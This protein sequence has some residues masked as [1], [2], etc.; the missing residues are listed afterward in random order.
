MPLGLIA[1]VLRYLFLVALLWYVVWVLRAMMQSMPAPV[2]EE[3]RARAPRHS[4]PRRP[5]GPVAADA[6]PAA[7]EP[8]SPP[9]AESGPEPTPEEAPERVQEE[10]VGPVVVQA[11]GEA[12]EGP[13]PPEAQPQQSV[14]GD[15][16]PRL[17]LEVVPVP[18]ISARRPA[19][20]PSPPAPRRLAGFELAVEEPGRSSLPRGMA[21][22]LRVGLHI[23]RAADNGLVID[24]PAVSRQHAYLGPRGDGWVLVDKGS[25]NGTFVNGERLRGP[26]KLVAGDVIELGGVR[27][28]FRGAGGASP[29]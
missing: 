29:G 25:V 23:G 4:A 6:L 7:A 12:S 10:P 13:W 17:P 16:E 9:A 15:E 19:R 11:V 8:V 27:L 28:V 5:E 26:R 3:T 18:R 24:D 2:R 22:P 21:V 1:L 14:L 20:K